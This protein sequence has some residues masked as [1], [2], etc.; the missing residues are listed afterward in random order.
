MA[1]NSEVSDFDE[2]ED[3]E[4]G[5]GDEEAGYRRRRFV[6]DTDDEEDYE[7][8]QPILRV[9]RPA[10]DSFV[11]SF[12]WDQEQEGT[13]EVNMF[14]PSMDFPRSPARSESW[15]RHSRRPRIPQRDPIRVN[16]R[17]PLLARKKSEPQSIQLQPEIE[18]VDVKNYGLNDPPYLAPP[19]PALN[20]KTSNISQKS[21]K[22]VH[23]AYA[24]R[25]TYGQTVCAFFFLMPE[26]LSYA[27]RYSSSIQSPFCLVS[28]CF[29]NPLHLR[30]PD[31][32]WEPS[33]LSLMPTSRAIRQSYFSDGSPPSFFI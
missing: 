32:Q 25:S 28:E 12:D 31:G 8:Q 4:T 2:E 7:G 1:P 19:P 11:T 6:P 3:E 13:A 22:S 16:E 18:Q 17:A 9:Q 27:R 29:R 15:A 5:D 14:T 21:H 23:Y 30:T 26:R 24:G 33:S 20:H 10:E